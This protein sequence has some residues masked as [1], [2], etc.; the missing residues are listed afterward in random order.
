M[1]YPDYLKTDHW[2]AIRLKIYQ[3][4]LN[5]KCAICDSTKELNIHH[6]T[7]DNLWRETSFDLVILCRGC[8]EYWHKHSKGL[9][10]TKKTLFRIKKLL[11]CGSSVKRSIVGAINNKLPGVKSKGRCLLKIKSKKICR[12]SCKEC[13]FYRK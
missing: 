1:S 9:C 7:Y 13:K 8:H 10:L 4:Q 12:Y 11:I 3:A 6:K 2:K 5:P